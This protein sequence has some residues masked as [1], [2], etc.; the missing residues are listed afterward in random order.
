MTVQKCM[1]LFMRQIY[2][3]ARLK[4][5][6]REG[7]SYMEIGS[8]AEMVKSGVEERLGSGYNVAVRSADKNNGVTYTGLMVRKGAS[9][10]SPIIYLDGHF[11]EYKSGSASLSEIADSVACLGRKENPKIDVRKLLDYKSIEG[12]I[13]YKLI[14]TEQNR[15]LLE[16][17]P[18]MEFFDLSIVFQC[19]FTDVFDAPASI[20]I[21]NAHMKLWGK[22]A[23][24]LLKAAEENTPRI[25]GCGIKSMED[26][27]DE[28]IA[29]ETP[30]NSGSDI[31]K[32]ESEGRA[33]MYVLSNRY[34]TDGAACI[35]YPGQLE[36]ICRKLKSSFYIIPSSIH[37]L[38][39]VPADGGEESGEMI[40]IIK[41][42]NDTQLIPEEILSYS[43]YYYD[44][45]EKRLSVV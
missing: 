33:P 36:G 26:V 28:I 23:D 20:L 16:D 1:E 12:R 5:R 7:G 19:V 32:Q 17:V 29:A 40:G 3:C 41:E 15:E 44:G 22:T 14:N 35:L 37:E 38:L 8:F 10:I 34:R 13:A 2:A 9:D 42:V 4:G 45:E 31:L 25:M 24:D 43:L 27:L 11:E 6:G 21:H 18:H 30:D 39:I